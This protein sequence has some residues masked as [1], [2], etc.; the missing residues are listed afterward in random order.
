MLVFLKRYRKRKSEARDEKIA[1][2]IFTRKATLPM[3]KVEN[4]LPSIVK[5]GYP[6]GWATPSVLQT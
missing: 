2:I 1:E 3:D 5:R 6:V 4:T